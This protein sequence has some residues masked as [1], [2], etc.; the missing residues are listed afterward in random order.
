M[1]PEIS[2]QIDSASVVALPAKQNVRQTELRFPLKGSGNLMGEVSQEKGGWED[3][4]TMVL[5]YSPEL[6]AENKELGLM[7]RC[8]SGM[9]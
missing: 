2:F 1:Y 6:Y 9:P 5:C 4:H 7:L 3:L 8:G